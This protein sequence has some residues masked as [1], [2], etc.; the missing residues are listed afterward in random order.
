MN[1]IPTYM[2]PTVDRGFIA[3]SSPILPYVIDSVDRN[4]ELEW[5]ELRDAPT[6]DELE[7]QDEYLDYP[8]H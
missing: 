5:R 8:I 3:P 6:P 1:N 2:L 4:V 7:Y